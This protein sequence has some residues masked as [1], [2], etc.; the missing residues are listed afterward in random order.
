[1][2][3]LDTEHILLHELA[4]IKRGDLWV[5]AVYMTLQIVY[6]FNPLLW[7]IRRTLQNLRELCY[8]ATVAKLLKNN[9]VHYRQTL[10]ETARRLLAEPVDPGLGLLGLFEN[11]NWL[12][13]RL[14]W[15]E[16]KTWKNR[17]LRI[18]TIILLVGIMTAC[19]MPM[20]RKETYLVSGTVT[21]V[22]TGEPIA[23]AVVFDDGFGPKSMNKT[24][25]DA[26]GQ[27]TLKTWN[28]EHNI[29]ARA[30]GYELE[31]LTLKT[32]PF[33]N[34]DALHFELVSYFPD[35]VIEAVLLPEHVKSQAVLSLKTGKM[36]PVKQADELNEPFLKYTYTFPSGRNS[37]GFTAY[38]IPEQ[39]IGVGTGNLDITGGGV[40]FGRQIP[41]AS[42]DN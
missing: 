38:T 24:T 30:D 17:R 42:L 4:H 31:T 2:S 36:I 40:G 27:F 18:A 8:D 10:L 39:Y 19:V 7:L 14:K 32:V 6:W 21:D 15:L 33:D 26:E 28:E 35:D 23:G 29:T 11:S 12:V 3:K 22:Q 20:A 34:S 25:T 5:H 9:T 13:A 41:T 37:S 1:M 16:R